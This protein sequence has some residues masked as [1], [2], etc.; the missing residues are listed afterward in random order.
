MNIEFKPKACEG[1]NKKFDGTVTLRM[2]TFDEKYSY[3]EQCQFKTDESGQVQDGYGS[4]SAIRKAVG[5]AKDHFVKVDLI[6]VK[7]GREFKSFDEMSVDNDCH[8][9]LIEVAGKI[10]QGFNLGKK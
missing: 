1:K 3:L 2:P 9:I 8:E 10:L 4:I 5:L 7:D 6:R